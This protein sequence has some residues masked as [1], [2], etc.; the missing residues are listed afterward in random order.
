MSEQSQVGLPRENLL[1]EVILTVL[2]KGSEVI[3]KWEPVPGARMACEG[4]DL[5]V[6]MFFIRII[7]QMC[8]KEGERI[9]G[10]WCAFKD[11]FLT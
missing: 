1:E 5:E 10:D 2:T 3:W 7:D 11:I 6:N 4:A 8:L 9:L